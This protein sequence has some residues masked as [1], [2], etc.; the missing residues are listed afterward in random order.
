MFRSNSLS[1]GLTVR[2]RM[3]ANIV[4]TILLMSAGWAHAAGPDATKADANPPAAYVPSTS[5]H[6]L[7][8]WAGSENLCNYGPLTFQLYAGGRAVMID[9]QAT[10]DGT[11]QQN[12]QQFTFRFSGG[13]VVYTGIKNGNTISGTAQNGTSW[14]SWSVAAAPFSTPIEPPTQWAGSENLWH[15]GQLTFQFYPDG[16]A[17]MLDRQAINQ[18]TWQQNGQQ[19]NLQFDFGR[20]QYTGTLNGNTMSGTAHN[21]C[22]FW[23]WS[24]N[25]LAS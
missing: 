16:R 25:R 22:S 17:V 12:G 21:D 10:T 5:G 1:H 4:P 7:T 15:Y 8:Q 3:L 6:K 19:I 20:V 23:S 18:G 2:S 13:R 9:A 14:W 11:W 24:I